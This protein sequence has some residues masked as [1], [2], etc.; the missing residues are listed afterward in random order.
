MA[1]SVREREHRGERSIPFHI[2]ILLQVDVHEEPQ[3]DQREPRIHELPEQQTVLYQ[4]EGL[5]HVHT[6]GEDIGAVPHVV[7][8][9][10]NY[11]PC[12]HRGEAP[13]W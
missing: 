4:V 1:Y 2:S 12:A 9:G 5:G 6:A 8:D 7:A 11:T 10:L 3:E 13:D